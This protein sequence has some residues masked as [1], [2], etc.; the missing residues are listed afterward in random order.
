MLKQVK[1]LLFP[2]FKIILQ[3]ELIFKLLT[4]AFFSPLFHE[5][6]N[7]L[8]SAVGYSYLTVENFLSFL[9][10]PFVW[11]LAF[12]LFLLLTFYAVFDISTILLLLDASRQNKK[13]VLKDILVL[14]F[15]KSLK[16]FSLPNLLI[17]FLVLFLIPLFNLGLTTSFLGTLRIPEFILEYI[18]AHTILI[19]ILLIGIGLFL[20]L[21]LKWLYALHY[22]VLEDCNFKEARKRS[23]ALGKHYHIMDCLSIL[24]MQF[25]V[26]I[27]FCLLLGIGLALLVGIHFVLEQFLLIESAFI[28]IVWLFLALLFCLY[29]LLSAPISYAIVSSL[30]Y[31]HKEKQGEMIVPVSF[32]NKEQIETKREKYFKRL[33]FCASFLLGTLFTYEVMVGNLELFIMSNDKMEVTAHRG[34]SKMYPE[35]TMLAFKKAKELDPDWIELDVHATQDGKIIVMHDSS[36]KRTTGVKKKIWQV[37][38]DEIKDLDVGILFGEEFRGERI[39]LL[40]DVLKWAKENKMKL[41]IEMKPSGNETNFELTVVELIKKYDLERDCVISSQVYEVLKTV[42]QLDDRIKTGYIMPFAFGDYISLEDI[43]FFSMEASNINQTIVDAIHKRGK[44]LHVWTVNTSE[45]IYK[46]IELG[47][48]NIITDDVNL[49]NQL[50]EEKREKNLIEEAILWVEDLLS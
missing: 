49:V 36:L 42:K 28:T 8:L 13:V 25:F 24:G 40:E 38:Y 14:S 44:R 10:E 33:F 18:N 6:M 34:D 48:D 15:K 31:R 20:Y 19:F 17:G 29:L 7:S 12:L 47:V 39:P 5:M 22:Y 9:S 41:N 35:N 23:K 27:V 50:I 30:Y 46:M 26:F 1:Q 4:L 11:P 3:F 45:N 32:I 21:L 2:N 37:T 43:D 16:V